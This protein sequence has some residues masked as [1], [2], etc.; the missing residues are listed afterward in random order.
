MDALTPVA[1][2]AFLAQFIMWLGLP[3]KSAEQSTLA[4][5]PEPEAVAA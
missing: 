4:T 2:I 5:M 3:E 1:L